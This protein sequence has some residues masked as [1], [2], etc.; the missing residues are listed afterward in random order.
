MMETNNPEKFPKVVYVTRE[1]PDKDGGYLT[2]HENIGDV[3]EG[4][5]WVAFVVY[6]YVGIGRIRA[7][8]PTEHPPT[9]EIDKNLEDLIKR[10]D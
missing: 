8:R 9:I 5:E 6:Q 3:E 7:N 2:I 10:S 1:D 4:E